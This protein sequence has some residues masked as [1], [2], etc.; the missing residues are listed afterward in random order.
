MSASTSNSDWYIF[1]CLNSLDCQNRT[2][3]FPPEHYVNPLVDQTIVN[4]MEIM[5]SPPTA[6][7]SSHSI[8][9]QDPVCDENIVAEDTYERFAQP[10]GVI[11]I[12]AVRPRPVISAGS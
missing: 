1:K 5:L 2:N 4:S 10:L 9:H 11:P 3:A 7:S 8:R 6:G 12:F